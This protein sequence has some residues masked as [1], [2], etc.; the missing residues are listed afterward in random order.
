MRRIHRRRLLKGAGTL[1]MGGGRAGILASRRAPAFAQRT[2][3]HWLK[4]VDFVPVS[5]Q[6]LKGRLKDECEKALGISLTIETINGDGVQARIT[7]AIQA[8]TDPDIMMAV[9]NWA[10]LYGESLIGALVHVWTAPRM[11]EEK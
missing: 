5:D 11:Q 2:A 7:S 1:T 10:Q 4:F 6:L 8:K 9:S 3:L